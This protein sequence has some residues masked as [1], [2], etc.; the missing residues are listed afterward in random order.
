MKNFI[1]KLFFSHDWSYGIETTILYKSFHFR[2]CKRCGLKQ[3]GA[4]GKN[5]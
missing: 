3:G 5:L 4:N 1:C 2:E